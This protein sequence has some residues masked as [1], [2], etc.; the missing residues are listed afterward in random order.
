MLWLEVK[1]LKRKKRKFFFR[2]S[3]RNACEKDLVSHR[4]ALK[5]KKK[6]GETGAPYV[7]GYLPLVGRGQ[8]SGG[9]QISFST[10]LRGHDPTFK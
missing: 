7:S 10:S 5:R 8:G 4:F 9:L 3:V 2:M 1:N 6:F